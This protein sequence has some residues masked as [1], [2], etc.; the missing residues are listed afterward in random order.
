VPLPGKTLLELGY[1][2]RLVELPPECRV[3]VRDT[4]AE[5]RLSL[6][7]VLILKHVLSMNDY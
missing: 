2:R 3:G 6:K 5:V 4:V 7:Y 1:T